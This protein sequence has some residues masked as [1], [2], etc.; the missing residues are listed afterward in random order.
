MFDG[1]VLSS[2]R[3]RTGGLCERRMVLMNFELSMVGTLAS[4][5]V[6]LFRRLACTMEIGMVQGVRLRWQ[7]LDSVAKSVPLSVRGSFA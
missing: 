5:D 3:S 6:A 2:S 4:K 1:R 7:G